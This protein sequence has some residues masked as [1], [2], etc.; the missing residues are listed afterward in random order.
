MR[1]I[2]YRTQKS[3]PNGYYLRPHERRTLAYTSFLIKIDSVGCWVHLFF[4]FIN[5]VVL[6][7][8]L[9]LLTSRIHVVTTSVSSCSTVGDGSARY[10]SYSCEIFFIG[11]TVVIVAALVLPS[12][13]GSRT[14][15][16]E[17]AT[18][19]TEKKGSHMGSRK[20][21]II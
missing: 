20:C 9:S 5:H 21:Y 17:V 14:C 19:F 18:A 11:I 7:P 1:K 16:V 4:I 13:S 10:L 6:N 12:R 2:K 8:F 3:N 15:E